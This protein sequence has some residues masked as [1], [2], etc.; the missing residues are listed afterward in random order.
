[1]LDT[2][3]ALCL[4]L[5]HKTRHSPTSLKGLVTQG[6]D[7]FVGCAGGVE[8]QGLKDFGG[9]SESTGGVWG[10]SWRWC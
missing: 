3:Q 1:M 4:A 9:D 2:Q 10:T 7:R 6:G 8:A 5:G